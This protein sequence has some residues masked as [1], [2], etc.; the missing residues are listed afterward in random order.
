MLI[1]S[2]SEMAGYSKAV[3]SSLIFVTIYKVPKGLQ[4]GNL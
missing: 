4:M 2:Y 1:F 3:L